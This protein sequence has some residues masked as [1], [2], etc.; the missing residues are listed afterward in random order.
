MN[1]TKTISPIENLTGLAF[2]RVDILSGDKSAGEQAAFALHQI[3]LQSKTILTMEDVAE[4]LHCA[5]STV[6]NLSVDDLPASEG[7]GRFSLYLKSDVEEFVRKR[8]RVVK[9]G[10]GL[11]NKNAFVIEHDPKEVSGNPARRALRPL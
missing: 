9:R 10:T 11:G 3:A 8:K 1:D 6:Q 2:Q 7:A 4:I 5:V